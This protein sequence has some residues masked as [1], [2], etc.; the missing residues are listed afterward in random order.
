MV[1]TAVRIIPFGW[2]GSVLLRVVIRIVSSGD[3]LI[4]VNDWVAEELTFAQKV[5]IIL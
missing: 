2:P 3:S 1:E 5:L 4:A